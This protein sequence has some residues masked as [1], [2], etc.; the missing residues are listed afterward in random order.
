MFTL[1][2]CF[3]REIEDDL[4]RLG[5]DVPCQGFEV[6]PEERQAP[7]PN[8]VL[9]Q[10]VPPVMLQE[11][12]RALV[13]DPSASDRC[14]VDVA[15]DRVVDMQ[16]FAPPDVTRARAASRRSEVEALYRRAFESDVAVVTLGQTEAWWDAVAAQWC[17]Q[18][19]TP[20]M[21]ERHRDRFFFHELEL[22]ELVET[23]AATCELLFVNGSVNRILVTVSPVPL[24]SEQGVQ[25]RPDAPQEVRPPCDR[26]PS[27]QRVR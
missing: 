15:E 7:R 22:D 27:R 11:L 26:R 3:T 9:N 19:P 25:L 5:F 21:V 2:S 17:N 1:G 24:R 23:L 14:L 10:Y 8:S 13:N 12:R 20:A 16:L 4:C 6:P 18:L